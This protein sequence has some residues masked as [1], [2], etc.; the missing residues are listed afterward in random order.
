MEESPLIKTQLQIADFYLRVKEQ[1]IHDGYAPEIDWQYDV[2]FER[3]CERQFLMEGAWVIL[4]S[5]FRESILRQKFPAISCAF[6]DWDISRIVRC[7]DSCVSNALRTFAHSGKIRA[8]ATLAEKVHQIGLQSIKSGINSL[9]YSYLQQFP[10]IGP[11]T[12]IHLGKNLGLRLVKPDRHLV[13][14]AFELGFKCPQKMCEEIADIVG[15]PLEV[16]DIVLWRYSAIQVG[17]KSGDR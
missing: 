7:T 2:C 17:R 8:I 6:L 4:A 12:A 11:I 3:I 1:L 13:R 15:D 9:G 5:G 16:I 14:V 10:Y